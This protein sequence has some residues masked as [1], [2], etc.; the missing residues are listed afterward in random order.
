MKD[1]TEV[2]RKK[3]AMEEFLKD[4]FVIDGDVKLILKP[5]RYKTYFK[6]TDSKRGTFYLSWERK[7]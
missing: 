1:H 7:C 2:V 6:C 4:A 5:M 3:Q